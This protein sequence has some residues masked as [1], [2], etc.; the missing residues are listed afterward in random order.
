MAIGVGRRQV[1]FALGGAAVW[2]LAALAQ[3]PAPP[4]IGFLGSGSSAAYTQSLIAFREGLKESG[5]SG[6]NV[7]IENRWAE[8]QYDRLPAMAA[9]LASRHVALIFASALPAATAAKA[10]TSTIPIV[11]T[12]GSDPL[13]Y[14]LVASLNRPGG[15]ITGV[16]FLSN[17]LLAKQLELLNELVP[18]G[19]TVAVLV[20]PNNPNAEFDTR[21]VQSAA[22]TLGQKL[23][24]VKASA[25]RDFEAV[26][27]GIVQQRASALLVGGDPLFTSQRDQLVALA[28]RHKIPAVYYSREFAMA[29][30][31]ASYGTSFADAFRQAG[32]YSGRILM[33]AKP[34]DLPVMQPTKFELVINLKTAKSLGLTVPQT[35]LVAADEVIE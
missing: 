5:Y 34:A 31:L 8:G 32:I 6:Q 3:R 13:K 24:V 35:L 11:F 20:N 30:G 23:L 2:P 28:A 27:A 33:G 4:V 7:A 29:G 19:T 10:A 17:V 21:D 14:G 26:F 1:I 25:E 9:E 15:N 22:D 16:S 12:T 18:N